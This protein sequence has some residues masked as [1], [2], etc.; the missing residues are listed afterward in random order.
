M[1]GRYFSG[2]FRCRTKTPRTEGGIGEVKIPLLADM[3]KQIARSYGV[4]LEDQ[5]IPL[6][7]AESRM[8]G[9]GS[10][11]GLRHVANVHAELSGI[12]MQ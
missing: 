3:T 1:D 10:G 5:G 8:G 7:W 6:R 12:N 9:A 11:W 4:L 2:S